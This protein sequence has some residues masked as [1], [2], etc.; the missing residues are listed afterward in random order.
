MISRRERAVA[1]PRV[2]Q[3]ALRRAARAGGGGGKGGSP[4]AS[5]GPVE[6]DA[7]RSG[8]GGGRGGGGGKAGGGDAPAIGN[9]AGGDG[10]SRSRGGGRGKARDGRPAPTRRAVRV[11]LAM[12]RRIRRCE[13]RTARPLGSR[14]RTRVPG[15]RAAAVRE[16]AVGKDGGAGAMALPPPPLTVQVAA[17]IRRGP[18]RT[19][20]AAVVKVPPVKVDAMGAAVPRMAVAV[21]VVRR[22]M[23]AEVAAAIIMTAASR[24]RDERATSSM[25]R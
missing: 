17:P 14:V 21:A 19:R 3:T 25:F 24:T 16:R 1:A 10:S 8:K 9:G 6:E 20:A 4:A 5:A 11:V 13:R 15:V 18:R 7:R 2:A 22:P 12:A 23:E